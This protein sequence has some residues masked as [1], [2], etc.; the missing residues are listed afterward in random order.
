MDIEINM[1]VDGHKFNIGSTLW[2]FCTWDGQVVEAFNGNIMPLVD[3]IHIYEKTVEQLQ[4]GSDTYHRPYQMKL[5]S[6][7]VDVRCLGHTVFLDEASA[8]AALKC[9]ER[10]VLLYDINA[11]LSG[12][13]ESKIKLGKVSNGYYT[14]DDLMCCL[15]GTVC[16]LL[17]D[18]E[19]CIDPRKRRCTTKTDYFVVDFIPQY[20]TPEPVIGHRTRLVIP[21]TDPLCD[22]SNW[23]LFDIPE[24]DEVEYQRKDWLRDRPNSIVTLRTLIFEKAY[25]FKTGDGSE[26]NVEPEADN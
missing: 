26:I 23:E 25:E 18:G 11:L 13:T 1:I 10:T 8:Q 2:A 14:F 21:N 17:H 9:Y 7:W 4:G 6:S 22:R 15:T 24:G 16:N 19:H 12:R 3:R 5:G 20:R